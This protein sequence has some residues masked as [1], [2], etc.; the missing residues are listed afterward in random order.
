MAIATETFQ[1]ARPD[2]T[3]FTTMGPLARR[4]E[5]TLL[6]ALGIQVALLIPSFA[7]YLV[8]ERLLNGISVWSKPMKFQVSLIILIATLLLLLPT[9]RIE[10]LTSRLARGTA[11]TVAV[12]A[13]LEIAYVTLQAARG[14]ASHFNDSTQLE[15]TLYQVMGIGAVALVVCTFIF[16][17]M[18][19]RQSRPEVGVG[20]RTGAAW[21]LMMSAVLTL[22]T[23]GVLSSGAIDGPGHWVGGVKT[24]AGGLLLLGWSRSGGDL[25]VPHFFATHIMQALPLLGLGLDRLRPDLARAGVWIGAAL[26]IAVVAATFVQ[27]LSG[28]PFL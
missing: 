21:G 6:A 5:Q 11:L 4:A 13:T 15:A 10:A 17:W 1:P 12:S 28:R 26:G 27:A 25:R 18:I 7:A 23:A 16:G 3:A 19:W 14:R 8:D 24:D 22:I 9:L 2:T 20:L